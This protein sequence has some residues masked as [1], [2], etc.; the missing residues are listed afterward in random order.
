MLHKSQV[1]SLENKSLDKVNYIMVN[2]P[3]IF[4]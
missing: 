4:Q 3:G 1:I 2:M